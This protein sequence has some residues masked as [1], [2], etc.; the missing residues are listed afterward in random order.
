MNTMENM[1]EQCAELHKQLKQEMKSH[2]PREK[3][4]KPCKRRPKVSVNNMRI[5]KNGLTRST[6]VNR[7]KLQTVGCVSVDAGDG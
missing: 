5:F 6:N 4:G 7:R 2:H 1:A 3:G